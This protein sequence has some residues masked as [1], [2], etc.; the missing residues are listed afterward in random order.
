M[1][2]FLNFEVYMSFNIFNQGCETYSI[3][4]SNGSFHFK[5]I[6]MILFQVQRDDSISGSNG[7]FHFRF[8]RMNPFQV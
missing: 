4:G 5:F 8:K 1:N 7:L 6:W 2:L 3:T